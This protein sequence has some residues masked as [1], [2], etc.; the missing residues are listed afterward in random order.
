V[1]EYRGADGHGWTVGHNH[2]TVERFSFLRHEARREYMV[3][4]DNGFYIG[5]TRRTANGKWIA[6]LPNAE[7]SMQDADR[8]TRRWRRR[9]DAAYALLHVAKNCT[10]PT[11]PCSHD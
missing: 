7:T 10:S 11:P 1:A 9:Q 3:S 6:F 5:E 8:N 4:D 2:R